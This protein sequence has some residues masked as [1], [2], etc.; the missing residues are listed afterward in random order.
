MN[1]IR[2]NTAVALSAPRSTQRL[3]RSP[4]A[5]LPPIA[6]IDM[7]LPGGGGTGCLYAMAGPSNVLPA[8]AAAYVAWS[9]YSPACSGPSMHGQPKFL[10]CSTWFT[11]SYVY[12]PC[13]GAAWGVGW[14]RTR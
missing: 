7:T 10:P 8:H 1:Q 5:G 6:E 14:V 2:R 12:Q 9:L 13:E 11:S 3:L 4:F